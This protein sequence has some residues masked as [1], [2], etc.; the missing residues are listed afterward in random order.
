[1]RKR[2]VAFS[3]AICLVVTPISV[4]AEETDYSYLEETSV[5]ELRELDAV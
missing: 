1:M 4:L 2:I 5:K 3:T